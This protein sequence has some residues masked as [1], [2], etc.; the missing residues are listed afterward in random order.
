MR[1][2]AMQ[3]AVFAAMQL[4]AMRVSDAVAAITFVDAASQIARVLDES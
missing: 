1:V 2:A 4:A 3:H